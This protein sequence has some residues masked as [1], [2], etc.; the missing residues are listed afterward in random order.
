ML[1][2]ADAASKNREQR[3]DSYIGRIRNFLGFTPVAKD[4][5]SGH[6][7]EANEVRVGDV[8][9]DFA[10]QSVRSSLQG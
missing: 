10:N 9:K 7:D 8:R 4:G 1:F 5:D 6:L 2:S 3:S